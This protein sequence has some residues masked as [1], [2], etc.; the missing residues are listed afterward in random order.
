MAFCEG[1]AG[2][3]FQVLFESRRLGFV[4]E[5][6]DDVNS[7]RT[8]LGRVRAV[9]LIVPLQPLPDVARHPDVVPRR[10]LSRLEYVD[11]SLRRHPAAGAT[12]WP[13]EMRQISR[14][15]SLM[16]HKVCAFRAVRELVELQNL[17]VRPDF[18]QLE[19]IDQLD[20]AT[21]RLQGRRV[22]KLPSPRLRLSANFDV[23]TARQDFA[24]A[25]GQIRTRQDSAPTNG[26]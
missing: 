18:H 26:S 12:S 20:E 17:E 22:A 2:S 13:L 3:G 4:R 15:G 10:Q 14:L 5:L 21:R 24:P 1:S 7:P 8:V 16:D 6:D 25:N 11:E 9:P 19:P 23:R